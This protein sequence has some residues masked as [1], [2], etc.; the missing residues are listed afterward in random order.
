MPCPVDSSGR[1]TSPITDFSGRYIK[2]T[3]QDICAALKANGLLIHKVVR[4]TPIPYTLMC[5]CFL[6]HYHPLLC[7]LYLT[8]LL[9]H[10]SLSVSVMTHQESF[11][12]SYP[13]CWRSDTP[14]L[15]KAVPSW[16]VRVESIKEQLL[17]NNSQTYW[18]PSHVKVGRFHNWLQDAR[19][20]MRGCLLH[21]IPL[22]IS[23]ARPPHHAPHP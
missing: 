17:K 10:Y 7:V 2:D 8:C 15:Y 5:C 18:V 19:C 20:V 11:L 21:L 6:V 4:C 23:V 14:L 1:F 22:R 9:F 16:F 12:H 13:F 3:D